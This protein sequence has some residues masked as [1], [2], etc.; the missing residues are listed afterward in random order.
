MKQEL[1]LR[2]ITVEQTMP[3]RQS[4]LRPGLPLIEVKFPGDG[5]AMAMHYGVFY[6]NRLIAVGTIHREPCTSL[7]ADVPMKGEKAWRLRGMATDPEFRSQGSG[8][9]VLGACMEHARKNNGEVVWCNART[10]ALDFYLRHG[11]KKMGQEYDMPGI[12]PH[13]LMKAMLK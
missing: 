3:L 4:V 8:G 13:F 10:G 5:S 9:M 11:F 7:D 2:A 12:G 1:L 6:E